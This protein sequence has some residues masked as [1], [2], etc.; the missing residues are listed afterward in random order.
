[1]ETPSE[2]S[3]GWSTLRR[4]A[5]CGTESMRNMPSASVRP[6]RPDSPTTMM[7]PAS[8]PPFRLSAT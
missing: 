8:D 2:S 6:E 7:A 5:P 4:H 3:T 1:M